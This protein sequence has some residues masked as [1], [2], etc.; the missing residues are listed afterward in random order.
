MASES[1]QLKNRPKE[2]WVLRR[3]RLACIETFGC[4][5]DFA[6]SCRTDPR[7]AAAVQSDAR[8]EGRPKNGEENWQ[9]THRKRLAAR[10]LNSIIPSSSGFSVGTGVVRSARD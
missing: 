3:G 9:D 5:P 10:R 1:H 6:T 2:H 7:V 8:A 4:I